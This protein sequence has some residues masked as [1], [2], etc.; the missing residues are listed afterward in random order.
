MP[1]SSKAAGA[2]RL[3][4]DR[5][6]RKSSLRLLSEE[7]SLSGTFCGHYAASASSRRVSEIEYRGTENAILNACLGRGRPH[8]NRL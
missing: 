1:G 7:S 8:R 6:R 4:E 3:T 2:G 5:Q